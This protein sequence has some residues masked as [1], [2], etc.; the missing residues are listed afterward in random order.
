VSSVEQQLERPPHE[1]EKSGVW[2]GNARAAPRVSVYLEQR[3]A[4][5]H[6]G[7]ADRLRLGLV[8]PV[9]SCG[10]SSLLYRARAELGAEPAFASWAYSF[11]T[12][13]VSTC[14]SSPFARMTDANILLRVGVPLLGR[15]GKQLHCTD[16]AVTIQ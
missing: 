14:T 11:A 15:L 16:L 7:F 13:A 1:S 12:R 10:T 6:V 9:R 8:G 4:L 2:A 5:D 3:A